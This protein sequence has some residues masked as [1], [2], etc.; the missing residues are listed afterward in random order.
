MAQASCGGLFADCCERRENPIQPAPYYAIYS[1]AKAYV[2][3]FS[4]AMSWELKG[5][6]VTLSTVCPG[7]TATEFHAAADHLKPKSMDKLTMSAESVAAI[8]L[9][10]MFKGR[11]VVTPGAPNK[12]TAF[13]AKL[14]P[15]RLLV[16][17]AGKM[18]AQRREE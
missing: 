18:M 17:V 10:A 7:L 4:A 5:T 8:G 15:R 13:F 16:A 1:A 9:K 11:A 14:L 12:L 6:G 3:S 2:L